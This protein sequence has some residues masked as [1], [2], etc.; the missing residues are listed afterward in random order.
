MITAWLVS[1]LTM[2]LVGLLVGLLAVPTARRLAIVPR[3][4]APGAGRARRRGRPAPDYASLLDA[5]A[6][7]FAAVPV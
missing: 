7:Q 5:I 6:R 3:H 4:A 1:I 2:L